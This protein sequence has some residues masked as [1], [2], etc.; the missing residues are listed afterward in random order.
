[1]YYSEIIMSKFVQNPVLQ[2]RTTQTQVLPSVGALE[3]YVK[4]VMKLNL[5]HNARCLRF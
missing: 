4:F 1:M 3:N 5:I 2:N